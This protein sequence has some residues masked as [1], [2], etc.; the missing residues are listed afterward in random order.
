MKLRE[1]KSRFC[2]QIL[3]AIFYLTFGFIS[4]INPQ[5]QVKISSIDTDA[6]SKENQIDA[7]NKQ[8]MLEI[9]TRTNE[10][11]HSLNTST[12]L[13]SNPMEIL[14]IQKLIFMDATGCV[15]YII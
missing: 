13:T 1:K 8:K 9:E 10:G 14:I 2:K 6:N 12:K 7:A 4:D 3:S 15:T 11:N 5:D